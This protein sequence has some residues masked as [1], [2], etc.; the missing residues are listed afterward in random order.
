MS[1]VVVPLPDGTV[2]GRCEG[3]PEHPGSRGRTCARGPATINQVYDPERILYPMKRV[4][5]RVEGRWERSTEDDALDAIAAN[6]RTA[7][8][9]GRRDEVI[10]YVG[11]PGS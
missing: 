1:N 7:F 3:N 2:I 4:G 5:E 6:I 10:Y 8:D 9:E 11:R